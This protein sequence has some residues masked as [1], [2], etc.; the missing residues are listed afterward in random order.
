MKST[1]TRST[2]QN[3][4]NFSPS[5]VNSFIE[6]ESSRRQSNKVLHGHP[7]PMHWKPFS[8]PVQTLLEKRADYA[9][10]SDFSV[11]LYVGTPFCLKTKPARCG[12]CLFPSEDYRGNSGVESYLDILE[13][14]FE[15]YKPYYGRDKLSSI[16][17]GGGTPNLYRPQHYGR[18][19]G[20]VDKLYEGVPDDIEIT[21]EGIPQLFNEEKIKAI[22]EA[23]FNRISMGVQQLNEDLIKYSGRKQTRQQ[24][25]NAL[26]NC[27]KY[28]LVSSIDLIYGWPEQTMEDML[29]DLRIAVDAGVHHLTHYELNVAGR[30]DFASKAKRDLLPS[31]QT[32][33]EMYRRAKEYLHSQGFEQETVYD[34]KRKPESDENQRAHRYDYEHNMHDFVRHE[35]GDIRQTQQVCGIGFS[36][37]NFHVNGVDKETDS[38][39][40]MNHTSLEKYVGKMSRKEFPVDRGFHYNQHDVKLAWLFQSMQ[41]MKID[42]VDYRQIFNENL[43]DTYSA[44]WT[45]IDKRGWIKTT[46]RELQFVD[47]GQYY[48]PMLQALVA[49][50]RLAQIRD[51][52]KQS[53]QNI[54]VVTEIG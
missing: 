49:S 31:I 32:N 52:R 9:R 29:E 41:T 3:T 22:K 4:S 12:F 36:A 38:W 19:M 50:K 7:S 11:N 17:F 18:L 37:V 16:Y 51:E 48:I 25:Y 35:Q 30:S 21:L 40:Y 42:Y 28:D 6:R 33:K 47:D 26:E 44:V 20:F 39:I 23:G 45:D 54:E 5:E 34:W 46:D 43:L 2:R 8:E 13:Q 10:S 27:H 24:V 53:L 15:M 1:S 14:E